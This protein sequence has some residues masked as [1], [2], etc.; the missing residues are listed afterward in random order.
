ME[1][2][3]SFR[4]QI[5]SLGLASWELCARTSASSEAFSEHCASDRFLCYLPT[6]LGGSKNFA[7]DFM[8]R[9]IQAALAER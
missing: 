4:P 5:E 3:A 8:L 7:A 1:S 9:T 2:L 6:L